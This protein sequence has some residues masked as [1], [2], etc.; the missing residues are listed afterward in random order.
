MYQLYHQILHFMINHTPKARRRRLAFNRGD[1]G[2]ILNTKDI[3]IILNI[4]HKV[5]ELF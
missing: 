5:D 3:S 2:E 1:E 4:F